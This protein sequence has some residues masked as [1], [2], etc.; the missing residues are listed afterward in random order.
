MLDID[1]AFSSGMHG[2]PEVV[3]SDNGPQYSNEAHENFSKQYQFEHKTSSPYYPQCNCEAER[4]MRTVK[5]LLK[6]NNDPYLALLA[7]R[8]TPIQD[9]KYSPAE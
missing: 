8:T 6:K 1:K 5:E 7:Y 3:F 4:V 9:W 2:M